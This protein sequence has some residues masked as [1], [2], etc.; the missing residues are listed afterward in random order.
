MLLILVMKIYMVMG[1][2]NNCRFDLF[3]ENGP[4]MIFIR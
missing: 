3:M 1:E 2:L 4:A